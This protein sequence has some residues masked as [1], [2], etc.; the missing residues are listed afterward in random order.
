ME[1]SEEDKKRLKLIGVIVIILFLVAL[2][3]KFWFYTLFA[4]ACFTIGFLVGR[5]SKNINE[6]HTK[7]KGFL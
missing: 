1:V 4:L 5:K 3:I 6:D 7:R 2:M